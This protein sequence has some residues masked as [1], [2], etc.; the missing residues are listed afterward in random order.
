V[1]FSF[2]LSIYDIFTMLQQ[3]FSLSQ[4]HATECSRTGGVGI[5]FHFT[6][7]VV[8]TLPTATATTPTMPTIAIDITGI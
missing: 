4:V 7:P 1:A 2:A 5:G 3:F 8:S 6:F